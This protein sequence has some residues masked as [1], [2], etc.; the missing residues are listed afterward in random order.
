MLLQLYLPPSRR[1]NTG[2]TL[3]PK[4]HLDVTLTGEH[5]EP[6]FFLAAL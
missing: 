5:L 4:Y 6:F 2:T 1:T 3:L